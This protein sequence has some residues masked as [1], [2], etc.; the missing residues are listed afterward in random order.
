M[1]WFVVSA[2]RNLGVLGFSGEKSFL[3]YNPECS[4]DQADQNEPRNRFVGASFSVGD[5]VENGGAKKNK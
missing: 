3:S 2:R 4:G 1:D 5:G